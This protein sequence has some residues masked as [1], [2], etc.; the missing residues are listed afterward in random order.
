MIDLTSEQLATVRALVAQFLGGREVRAFGSRV[1]G[2]SRPYS[3]LDLAVY[4]LEPLSADTLRLLQEA[5]EDSTLPFRVDIVDAC[6]LSPTFLRLMGSDTE[7]VQPAAAASQC[8]AT[9]RS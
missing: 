9:S 4:G 2:Q 8:E 3:D 1:R 7:L 6:R 5:F